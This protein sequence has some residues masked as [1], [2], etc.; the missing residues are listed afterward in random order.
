MSDENTFARPAVPV[1]GESEKFYG[2]ITGIGIARVDDPSG[3]IPKTLY[4]TFEYSGKTELWEVPC[5]ELFELLA[6]HLINMAVERKNSDAYG[7]SKLWISRENG[8]WQA[9]EP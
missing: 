8:Q 3:L 9:T 1:I 4:A 2:Y 5:V 7:C 6:K